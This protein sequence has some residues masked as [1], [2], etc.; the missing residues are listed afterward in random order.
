MFLI[1]A[2]IFVLGLGTLFKGTADV[3]E[4]VKRD[5]EEDETC[6]EIPIP[7]G[8]EELLEQ[9]AQTENAPKIS[10]RAESVEQNLR[11]FEQFSK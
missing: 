4:A 2:G 7:S 10:E 6:S 11:A 8:I 9:G 1:G 5:I 3:I